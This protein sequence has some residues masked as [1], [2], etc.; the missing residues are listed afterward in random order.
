MNVQF[1]RYYVPNSRSALRQLPESDIEK[2]T[3]VDMEM[4]TPWVQTPVRSFISNTI[5]LSGLG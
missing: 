1:G 4:G 2:S 5:L 3:G